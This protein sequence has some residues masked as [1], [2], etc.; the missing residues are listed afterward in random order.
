MES[1]LKSLD[2]ELRINEA[3]RLQLQQESYA[4]QNDAAYI[5]RVAR[6]KLNLAA[7]GETLF[8]FDAAAPASPSRTGGGN[9][10]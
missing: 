6:D 3:R 2:L 10:R 4:L 7:P 5:E 8:Q 9:P 1:R